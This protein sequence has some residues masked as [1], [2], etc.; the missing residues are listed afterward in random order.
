VIG[1]EPEHALLS[2]IG[3]RTRIDEAL[4]TTGLDQSVLF[5]GVLPDSELHAAYFAAD[6]LVFPIQEHAHDIEGFGMV[7]LEAAAHGLPTVA[8]AAGGVP[9]AVGNGVSGNLIEPNDHSAF[10]RAVLTR[11]GDASHQRIESRASISAFASTFSWPVFG[12]RLRELV[13]TGDG[14]PP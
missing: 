1:K 11:L 3:E 7:A 2:G 6:V 8:F 13:W 12:K 14:N 9:D 4:A 10:A 5:L